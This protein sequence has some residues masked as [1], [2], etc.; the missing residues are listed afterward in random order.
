[1]LSLHHPLAGGGAENNRLESMDL[2]ALQEEK[3]TLHA[4]LKAYERDFR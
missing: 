4:Y 1:M 3:K 2:D